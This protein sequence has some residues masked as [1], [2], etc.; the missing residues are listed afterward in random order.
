MEIIFSQPFVKVLRTIEN[1]QQH[2]IE[3]HKVMNLFEDKIIADS[4]LFYLKDVL[5]ISYKAFSQ[6][7]GFLYLHTNQGLFSFVVRSEPHHF[8]KEYNRLK[9]FK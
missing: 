3:Q 2:T 5:D 6:D 7:Y 9:K 4:K 1:N 8:I